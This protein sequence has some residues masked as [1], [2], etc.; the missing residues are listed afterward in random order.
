MT[1]PVLFDFARGAIILLSVTAF[2]LAFYY[3]YA[4]E[5]KKKPKE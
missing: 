3:M 2:T 5:V 4:S 1:I